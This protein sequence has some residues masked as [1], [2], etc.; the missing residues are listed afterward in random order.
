[1]SSPTVVRD[2]MEICVRNSQMAGCLMIC[3]MDGDQYIQMSTTY[4]SGDLRNSMNF[5]LAWDCMLARRFEA[6]MEW[7]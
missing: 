1:M 3:P 6:T 4:A 2:N 7:F 5:D